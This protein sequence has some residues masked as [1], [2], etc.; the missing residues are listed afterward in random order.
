MPK[1]PTSPDGWKVYDFVEAVGFVVR[2]TGLDEAQV[3]EVI[4]AKQRYL[5]LAGISEAD[6]DDDALEAERHLFAGLMP[7]DGRTLDWGVTEYIA[8]VT[9]HDKASVDRIGRGESAYLDALGLIEWDSPEERS[10]VLGYPQTTGWEESG[11]GS[12]PSPT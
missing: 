10:Q 8:R 11:S 3:Q 6:P 9:G 1:D 7:V 2:W 5:E 12:P 4:T